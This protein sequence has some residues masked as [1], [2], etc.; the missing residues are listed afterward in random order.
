[1]HEVHIAHSCAYARFSDC[2]R[3][4]HHSSTIAGQPDRDAR[5]QLYAWRKHQWA[6]ARTRAE[7]G[8]KPA[9]SL[10][11]LLCSSCRPIHTTR[12]FRPSRWTLADRKSTRLNSSHQIISYAVFC[13]KKKKK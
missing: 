2:I 10:L 1:M 12:V 5:V 11:S 6:V 7:L 4:A 8:S 13:L 3:R 9:R